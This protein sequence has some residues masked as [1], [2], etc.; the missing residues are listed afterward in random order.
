MIVAT[1][2]IIYQERKRE[3]NRLRINGSRLFVAQ[4]VCMFLPPSHSPRVPFFSFEIQFVTH[5]DPKLFVIHLKSQLNA[6]LCPLG[7]I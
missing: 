5:F 7:H 3:K 1:T 4:Y 2:F 6:S